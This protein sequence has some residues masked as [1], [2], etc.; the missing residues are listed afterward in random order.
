MEEKAIYE[1]EI[2]KLANQWTNENRQID[3]NDEQS[4][5]LRSSNVYPVFNHKELDNQDS[6]S[7]RTNDAQT[8][9]DNLDYLKN[10]NQDFNRLN[11]R[12]TT[13]PTEVKNRLMNGPRLRRAWKKDPIL[14][15]NPLFLGYDKTETDNAA[16][17][18]DEE[19]PIEN[20]KR[21]DQ[22]MNSE[23]L[24]QIEQNLNREVDLEEL[25]KYL[26]AKRNQL[27]RTTQSTG[28]LSKSILGKDVDSKEDHSKESKESD[29]KKTNENLVPSNYTTEL[30]ETIITEQNGKAIKKV[31]SYKKSVEM[32][33]KR[34]ESILNDGNDDLKTLMEDESNL[35]FINQ[36]NN[37]N[38]QKLSNEV[39][40]DNPIRIHQR[41]IFD[42]YPDGGLIQRS[43]FFGFS[44]LYFI[45]IVVA[46]SMISILSVIGAGYCFYR[47]QQHNKATANVDYPAYGVIGPAFKSSQDDDASPKTKKN[48]LSQESLVNKATTINHQSILA[49]GDNQTGNSDRKLAQ[50]AQM[51]HYHHQKQQMISTEK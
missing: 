10:V 16:A 19:N 11:H 3:E 38:Y 23:E 18:L 40:L 30:Q 43:K 15:I 8:L 41:N 22:T 39:N 48:P 42:R 7:T 32:S 49:Q 34:S 33:E 29:E 44:D 26:M 24:N 6:L 36:P 37:A 51:Y 35:L 50:S 28:T 47:F 46:C 4:D 31:E 14:S 27:E 45:A 20:Q 17:G 13:M 25:T 9:I 12:L 2:E 21:Q 5:D 1:N